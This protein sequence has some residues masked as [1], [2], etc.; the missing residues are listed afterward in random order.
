M[1][2]KITTLIEN[3]EDSAGVLT[4]EH[5]L[6]LLI[7][8][9]G[10]RMLMDTGQ[11]GAFY[12]NAMKMGISLSDIDC[13]LLSHAHYDHTGGF[14]RLIKEEGAPRALYVG[15]DFF[16]KCYHERSDG[17]MKYIGTK[18][19]HQM[20]KDL[21]VP[22]I[23]IRENDLSIHDG[24]SLHRHFDQ[25]TDYEPLNP[26]FFYQ[27]ENPSC[28]PFGR[29]MD[30]LNYKPDTFEDE[31]V[32]TLDTDEG[33]VV[34]AACAHPGIVNILSAVAKRTGKRV[35]GF[36]GGTHLVDADEDRVSKTAESFKELGVCFVAASHCTGD[37]NIKIFQE[38]FGNSF[39]FNCTGNVIHL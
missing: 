33:L 35:Y 21:G 34:I 13:V 26:H 3:H 16:R 18:F 29:C 25:I 11:S 24:V 32:L 1:N 19:D 2:W 7:E 31:T 10:F 6:S 4:C 17:R 14:L 8:G 38:C 27:E 23:E 22:I 36:I 12:D 39:V 9:Q 20:L 28:G 15:K 30:S 37:G 5:G